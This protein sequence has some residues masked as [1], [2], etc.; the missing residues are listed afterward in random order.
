M[1]LLQLKYFSAVARFEHITKA[2]EYLHIAQP[3]VSQMI[4]RLEKELGIQLF[5]RVGKSIR[6]NAYGRILLAHAENVF[7]T[8][9]KAIQEIDAMKSTIDQK[10]VVGGWPGSGILTNLLSS[11]SE[12]Y[13]YIE[14]EFVQSDVDERCDVIFSFSTHS[15]PKTH[16]SEILIQEE[17]MLAIP[18]RNPLSR[19]ES[20]PLSSVK[21]EMFIGPHRG[22][23]ICEMIENYCKLAGFSPRVILEHDSA[24]TLRR[25]LQLGLG[26]AFFPE[27]TWGFSS[28]SPFFKSV[29]IES[30]LCIRTLYISWRNAGECP[31][32]VQMLTSFAKAYFKLMN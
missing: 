20:L 5:D 22:K 2:A 21:D 7:D 26:I 18:H 11:F 9:E 13:P 1:D 27:K 15:I 23:P 8:L 32:A 6:L 16:S 12:K 17:L 3:S 28:Q 25:M 31:R 10:V 29:H 19:Y 14:I 24:D 4:S 30:P